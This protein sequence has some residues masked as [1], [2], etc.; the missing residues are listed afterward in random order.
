[1]R[2]LLAFFLF[3][4]GASALCYE[5]L[6]TRQFA[7]ILGA[8][9]MAQTAVFSS[10]L[11]ALALGAWWWGRRG[12]RGRTALRA[13]GFME[14]G[15]AIS[16][17]GVSY[18]LAKWEISLAQL[19][20][21]SDSYILQTILACLLAGLSMGIPAFLL[22]GTLPVLV[23]S[24][25][26]D[27]ELPSHLTRLYGWNTLGAAL[28]AFLTGT[29]SIWRF[30]IEG[31]LL[32]AVGCNLVI[33][34]FALA[35]STRFE[36]EERR[37]ASVPVVSRW[38][39]WAFYSGFFV[40]AYEILWGRL[41]RYLLGERTLATSVLLSLFLLCLGAASLLAPSLAR[42]FRVQASMGWLL[43]ICATLQLLGSG[44]AGWKV[45]HQSLEP[46]FLSRILILIALMALPVLVTGLLFPLV[47]YH[48]E[49]LR[50]SPGETL[51]ILYLGNTLGAVLGA[52]C[53]NFAMSRLTGT[54]GA[55][56]LL[57][58]VLFFTGAVVLWPIH[59]S[60]LLL[61]L[62]VAIL[63]YLYYPSQLNYLTD[64]EEVVARAENEYGV[65]QIV[66]QGDWLKIRSNRLQLIAEL[67][68]TRTDE[69][70]Q[71]AAHFPL[72]VSKSAEK[73]LNIGTGYGITAGVF[74]LYDEPKS[75][76][77][78]ELLP[79]ISDNLRLF[80]SFNF[81]FY[82]DPRVDIFVGD[83]RH[84]LLAGDKTY[85]IITV[86]VLD[87]YLPGSSSLYT[88]DFWGEARERLE[89]G[90]VYTQLVWG[91]HAYLLARGLE[92]V[93]PT[94]LY[95]PAYQGPCYNVVAFRDHI[96]P[97]NITL[98]LQRLTPP[99]RQALNR[100]SEQ[101]P[102]E[103]LK[104]SLQEAI[105]QRDQVGRGIDKTQSLPLH[106]E[107]FP[108]LEYTWALRRHSPLDSALVK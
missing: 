12:L 4:S 100:F 57:S 79:F 1:M 67:G 81:A 7:K 28:G 108:H 65:Q 101:A 42:R 107:D 85:D 22:G 70:Q 102:E 54:M 41:A 63:G 76:E 14:I 90:G 16:A 30:G 37:V 51:G 36:Q 20:T 44:V 75:I 94:V 21:L 64:S 95:S 60:S 72:M 59:K 10:Y 93:F 104:A 91:E 6:W 43:M 17:L 27:S 80:E 11:L 88:V 69:A 26:E 34:L 103:L 58:A 97:E 49:R 13:Y 40:L 66:R 52:V 19:S 46:D 92:K 61:P 84:R 38:I 78:A 31:T 23:N 106:T 5:V 2:V 105:A 8:T 62:V 74:T 33:G 56:M 48:T 53:A 29:Y 18:G 47:V 55:M 25:P 98:H 77:T 35:L 96:L 39:A 87:P 9:G 86:N 32:I 99:A 15:A 24:L 68:K 73:V 89:P 3:F 82:Q 83:G 45:A 50:D 71:M